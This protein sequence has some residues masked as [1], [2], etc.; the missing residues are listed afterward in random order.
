[1]GGL[2]D[3]LRWLTYGSRKG[4]S[5]TDG[6]SLH[7]L[8]G[9][10]NLS[11]AETAR[12]SR[13][14]A[15]KGAFSA[16]TDGGSLD[17]L[18]GDSIL[19]SAETARGS[20]LR[21]SPDESAQTQV[22]KGDPCVPAQRGLSPFPPD[23]GLESLTILEILG[24]GAFGT[25]SK[26]TVHGHVVATKR[27]KVDPNFMN[28][29][30]ET[31]SLLPSHRNLVAFYGSRKARTPTGE[32]V[33]Y[34]VMEFIPT[35]LRQFVISTTRVGEAVPLPTALC[36]MR[37]LF[38][39]LGAVHELG[40]CH[41]DLKPENVLVDADGTLKLCDF[42]SA[43]KL[44]HGAVAGVT[45]IASRPYRAP[46]LLCQFP[47]YTHAIDIWASGCIFAELLSGTPLF[48]AADNV[49]V[50]ARQV[51]IRGK[52]TAEWFAELCGNAGAMALFKAKDNLRVSG[53]SWRTV[54]SRPDSTEEWSA[55]QEQ[56]VCELLDSL[57]AWAP[58]AR[59][60]ATRA[61]ELFALCLCLLNDAEQGP[62]YHQSRGRISAA[63]TSFGRT[64]LEL[65]H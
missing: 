43:K 30:A 3:G 51:K 26:A 25:V 28:R 56:S 60:S 48:S 13:L 36:L 1:M 50:L 59:P 52:P 55:K 38:D 32:T 6:G 61:A 39:G 16:T 42:G 63:T 29:E 9:D 46:E 14:P 58:S 7:V 41:R 35:N 12:G 45:Y 20:R 53:K 17:S 33:E 65:T 47:N 22:T 11:S 10:G 8:T 2:I 23:L 31:L 62:R 5:T 4:R 44:S 49:G 40:I 24:K 27:I 57:L 64:N 18:T 37:Q 34:L 54:L 21:E 15:A 19:S